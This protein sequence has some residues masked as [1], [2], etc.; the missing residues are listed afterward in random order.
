LNRLTYKI[1]NVVRGLFA[2][3]FKLKSVYFLL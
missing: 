1:L 3:Y 2:K